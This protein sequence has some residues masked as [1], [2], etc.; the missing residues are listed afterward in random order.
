MRVLLGTLAT[1][2][3]LNG[4]A[5]GPYA[6][7]WHKRPQLTGP[8]DRE[9]LATAE[10]QLAKAMHEERA[11]PLVAMGDCLIALQISSDELRRNPANTT[12]V[13]DYNFGVRRLFQFI[14]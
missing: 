6:E 14:Q 8:T 5:T 1:A 3:I 2:L 4:C 10:Q 11:K 12:A 7:V 13:R 9:P